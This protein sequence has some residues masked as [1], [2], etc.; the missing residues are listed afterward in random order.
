MIKEKLF[1]IKH[2]A[3]SQLYT[4]F[5]FFFAKYKIEKN[6][7]TIKRFHRRICFKICWKVLIKTNIYRDGI[8]DTISQISILCFQNKY[9]IHTKYKIWEGYNLY[10]NY[11]SMIYTSR[12]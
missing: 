7:E 9:F 1:L 4:Y 8:M 10:L 11:E 6:Y 5:F 12:Y 2:L 3:F